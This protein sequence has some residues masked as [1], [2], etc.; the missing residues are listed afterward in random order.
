MVSSNR[1]FP[2]WSVLLFLLASGSLL[3]AQS[4]VADLSISVR[5]RQP[6]TP[7][8]GALGQ[9]SITL[10][11]HG[12]DDAGFVP[13]SSYP[14][15]VYSSLQQERA[16][17]AI[18][19]YFFSAA[20]ADGCLMVATVVDPMPGSRSQWAY[21]LEFAPIASGESRT[22][23]LRYRLD[24]GTA[25]RE[26]PM[27]WRVRTYNETDPNPDNDQGGIVFNATNP[28]PHVTA[29]VPGLSPL[30][31]SVL[32]LAILSMGYAFRYR[33]PATRRRMPVCRDEADRTV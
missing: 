4:L 2:R 26:I 5:P 21:T 20:P 18:D 28:R 29:P 11:N 31:R 15:V 14:L 13:P 10:T 27:T 19:V 25:D 33:N 1:C 17:G 32:V 22:C 8:A 9:I 23:S 12:P 3:H 30:G 7:V 24:P 6:P 16:D